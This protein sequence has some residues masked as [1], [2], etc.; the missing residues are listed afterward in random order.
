[1]MRTMWAEVL[2]GE[3]GELQAVCPG[4]EWEL[5]VDPSSGGTRGWHLRKP[6]ECPFV[7]YLRSSHLAR[8][9]WLCPLPSDIPPQP[10]D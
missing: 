3:G 10:A 5:S 1:M 7:P 4:E 9:H 6:A 2:E 8:S